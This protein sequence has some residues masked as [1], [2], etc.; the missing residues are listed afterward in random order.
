M[1][2]KFRLDIKGKFFTEGEVRCWHVA[3]EAVAAPSLDMLKADW[4][5]P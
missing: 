2:E 1:E 4:M 5:V 3:R